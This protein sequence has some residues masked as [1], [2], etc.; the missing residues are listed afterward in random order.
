MAADDKIDAKGDQLKGKVKEGV[1][2]A[3][4][5]RDL[6]AEGHGDQAKGN[7]KQAGEKIK[8]VFKS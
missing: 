4:A 5:D 2:R 7:I 8:D 1:G 6:E 3:T